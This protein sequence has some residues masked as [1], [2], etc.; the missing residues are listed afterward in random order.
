MALFFRAMALYY[1]SGTNACSQAS[2]CSHIKTK[3][4]RRLK[5]V[6]VILLTG[7]STETDQGTYFWRFKNFFKFTVRFENR[8]G[9]ADQRHYN[10]TCPVKGSQD[11]SKALPFPEEGSQSSEEE[12]QLKNKNQTPKTVGTAGAADLTPRFNGCVFRARTPPLHPAGHGA[13]S[14]GGGLR[15]PR[16]S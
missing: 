3:V 11:E 15:R 6:R 16:V 2:Q 8:T 12:R 7:I 13:R 5:A 1:F 4:T 10:K 9:S 14:P